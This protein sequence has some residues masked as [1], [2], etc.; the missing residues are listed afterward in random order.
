MKTEIKQN[1][2]GEY[3]VTSP[4]P[5]GFVSEVVSETTYN[6]IAESLQSDCR[7]FAEPLQRVCRA[8][9]MPTCRLVSAVTVKVAPG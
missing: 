6:A 1:E 3:L 8:I 9:A 5:D 4:T 7:E 2:N